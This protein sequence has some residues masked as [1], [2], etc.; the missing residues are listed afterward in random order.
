M[1]ST[2]ELKNGENFVIQFDHFMLGFI[3][4]VTTIFLSTVVRSKCRLAS[5]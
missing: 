4:G 5:F 2:A 3:A 1:A